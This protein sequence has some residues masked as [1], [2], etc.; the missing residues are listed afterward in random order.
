MSAIRS[1]YAADD[2]R[3]FPKGV[4]GVCTNIRSRDNWIRNVRDEFKQGEAISGFCTQGVQVLH[5]DIPTFPMVASRSGGVGENQISTVHRSQEDNVISYN[6]IVDTQEGTSRHDGARIYVLGSQRDGQIAYDYVDSVGANI[7]PDDGSAYWTISNNVP[8]PVGPDRSRA[9]NTWL[10]VWT[11]RL[12]D[13]TIDNNYT[14]PTARRAK[15]GHSYSGPQRTRTWTSRSLPDAHTIIDASGL[16]PAYKD[17][18]V[19]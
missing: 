18:A 16:E 19:E 1:I 3:L 8:I 12:H 11:P 6:R 10:F 14:T 9:N 17:I 4:E 15:Q 7:Y 5:N 2:S 13:M